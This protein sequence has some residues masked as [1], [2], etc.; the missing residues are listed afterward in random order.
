MSS[1]LEMLY[2]DI[3]GALVELKEKH[4]VLGVKLKD[5][6]LCFVSQTSASKRAYFI[7]PLI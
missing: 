1:T 2:Q 7:M 3:D 6:H 5:I 4:K